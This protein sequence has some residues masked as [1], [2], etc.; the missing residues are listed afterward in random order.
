MSRFLDVEAELSS[1]NDY[2]YDDDDDEQSIS[3]DDKD[4][5]DDSIQ[6]ES[7]PTSAP[8]VMPSNEPDLGLWI[9][10]TSDNRS[11]DRLIEAEGLVSDGEQS[12]TQH[13]VV[14][15]IR[16]NDPQLLRTHE[17]VPPL[18]ASVGEKYA[19]FSRP[20]R[21]LPPEPSISY[22]FSA[23]PNTEET[24]K[25]RKRLAPD[26]HPSSSSS[27]SSA[28]TPN[29]EGSFDSLSLTPKKK[30]TLAEVSA[31]AAPFGTF[32][33][34]PRRPNIKEDWSKWLAGDPVAPDSSIPR[35]ELAPGEWVKVRKGLYRND[36]G[37][38]WRPD[39]TK[40]GSH[41]YFVLLVPRLSRPKELEP[42]DPD[43]KAPD[44]DEPTP[45]TPRSER[46]PPQLFCSKD[47]E[48]VERE[49]D[50]TFCFQR[51]TFSHGLLVKFFS[52]LSVTPTQTVSSD[53]CEL[54]LNSKHPF[55]KRFPF[56]LPEFF[57]FL[58]GDKVLPSGASRT[59]VITELSGESCVVG[60]GDMKEEQHPHS[61]AN[62]QKV[63]VPGDAIQVLAGE[64]SGK[65]GLVIE[66]HGSILYVIAREDMHTRTSFFVHIN[67]VKVCL[68]SFDPHND[69]PWFNLEVIVNRGRYCNMR[70]TVKSVRLTPLRDHI[71]LL[72][73]VTELACSMEV[74][75]DE[76][77]E[78]VT[79]KRLLEYQPLKVSQKAR[80]GVD[81]LMVK[82]RT[83]RVPWVGMRVKVTKGAHKGKQGIVRDVNRSNRENTDS[84]LEVSVK[85]Q[86]ISPNMS[87]RVEKIEYA[88]VREF[89]S[90]LEL[91]KS[92]PLTRV[93]EF[94]LPRASA[95]QRR[96][97]EPCY[98][99]EPAFTH[100]T[101][102]P[103]SSSGTPI[104]RSEYDNLDWDN[105]SDPWNP[106]SL[107][108]AVWQSP[109]FNP[110]STPT[111]PNPDRSSE[112]CSVPATALMSRSR[113]RPLPVSVHW[114]L[115]TKLLGISIR[116]AITGGKWKRKT[117]F[118]T[119]TSSAQ[120]VFIA[121]RNKD[122]VHP[123]DSQWI[124][125]HAQ[126][127]KPN[128]EQ[129]L[130]VVTSGDEQHIGKFVR[131][132]FYFYNQSPT[133]DARWFILGVV[134]RTGRQDSLTNEILELL[135]T[136]LG[137]VEESKEDRET[138]NALFESVRYAAKVGKPEVRR[139]GEGDFG[140]LYKACESA[141]FF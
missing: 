77:V 35:R 56:P 64:H 114:I 103:M 62:V 27:S 101:L 29:P 67:S 58:V 108:P 120:G 25:K 139:P 78:A 119:P 75:L 63:V 14:N 141:L 15:I 55:V 91:A 45:K 20:T 112:L 138:G 4:F 23:T 59:G 6:I 106:H 122:E 125:K 102:S 110:L 3:Q 134:D 53:F 124:K 61:L 9:P 133:D 10:S 26:L 71:K 89:D 66:R 31:S 5:I 88:H 96:P 44:P 79:S 37:M 34:R 97:K 123:I 128:S 32:A 48:G 43:A 93:Q 17:I 40:L 30:K 12:N 74:D 82:M 1:E 42:D 126:L 127:P 135:P 107:S 41:G 85:L 51:Q 2:D 76:V 68:L 52:E 24:M 130:M 49:S 69:I 21:V 80:F 100:H 111:S 46:S 109:D 84:G 81:E 28:P 65:E 54:F 7:H 50:Y 132:I 116:V 47:F 95:K 98:E 22:S 137:I 113:P 60:F 140:D 90:G 86:V 136:A 92:M 57:V 36:V 129:A 70:A 39:T 72:L 99:A 38:V 33:S 118:V 131:R 19:H 83:G 73:F 16:R 105:M 121:F 87:H 8:R 104:H 115:H 117:A 11:P 94:Y 18:P 13:Q